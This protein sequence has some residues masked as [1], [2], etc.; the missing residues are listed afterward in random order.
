MQIKLPLRISRIG[1]LHCFIWALALQGYLVFLVLRGDAASV[2][3][4]QYR[5]LTYGVLLSI[6][7]WLLCFFCSH[8]K[9]FQMRNLLLVVLFVFAVIFWGVL[10][11]INE[12]GASA[13]F[14][15]QGFISILL[16]AMMSY[17]CAI[18]S[19]EYRAI[20]SWFVKALLVLCL[21]RLLSIILLWADI[22]VAVGLDQ[23]T[24]VFSFGYCYYFVQA[25]MYRVH[26]KIHIAACSVFALGMLLAIQKPVFFLFLFISVVLLVL[27]LVGGRRDKK[28]ASAALF[29]VAALVF[30][31]LGVSTVLNVITHGA[32]SYVVKSE[33]AARVFKFHINQI[34]GPQAGI[35]DI[36]TFSGR[37]D[38][39]GGRF[40]LW[41]EAMS[42]F[43]EN[44]LL[45]LGFGTQIMIGVRETHPHNIIA[46]LL[47]CTG[48]IGTLWLMAIIV[49]AL[50]IGFCSLRSHEDLDLKIPLLAFVLG[51][52][53]YNLTGLFFSL[54]AFMYL[55][56]F[57]LGALFR[58]SSIS[59]G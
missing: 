27:L 46:Y 2:P 33:I 10:G 39:F 25:A 31:V 1:A 37:G 24:Y 40:N 13:V 26:R 20:L 29:V 15:M 3:W 38:L 18:K 44:K 55:F 35:V 57:C 56:A 4:L 42:I 5:P 14:E 58:L 59:Q 17:A 45:G 54:F 41:E 9:S 32:F 19:I 50:L 12:K 6:G 21:L 23:Y 49:W 51:F 48:L 8:I 53:W 34:G 11:L 47:M 7:S 22:Y 28:M 30:A 16:I 36:V 43:R 52:V